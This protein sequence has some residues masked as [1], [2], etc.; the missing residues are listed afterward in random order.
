MTPLLDTLQLLDI[1]DEEYFGTGYRN[2]ISNSR[3]KLMNPDQGGSPQLYHEGLGASSTTESLL[4]GS[5]VHCIVLQPDD[6]VIAPLTTRPTAKL[7]LVADEVYPKFLEKLGDYMENTQ[8]LSEDIIAA[9]NKIDYYK[10]KMTAERIQDVITKCDAYW[11]GRM[12]WESRSQNEKEPIFLDAKSWEVVHECIKSVDKNPKIQQLLHPKGVTQDPI[13]LNEGTLLMD[14]KAIV[15]GHETILKLK[16]KL[17][18]FT[19]D[20]E[21]NTIVLNDLKTTGHFI[22]DFGNGSFVNFHYARQMSFYLWLLRLYAQKAYGMEHPKMYA[23]MMLVSTIPDYRSGI[24]ACNTKEIAEGFKEFKRLLRMV[25]YCEVYGYD[26][27]LGT[28][29]DGSAFNL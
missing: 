3:L 27:G 14:V 17:D 2:Y 29:I 8:V 4:R 7:G 1:S 11:H 12:D 21:T 9:S 20:L 28:D 23:N 10:G 6:F 26:G 5:A 25:A 18:S 15:D 16:A 19:I 13:V 24:Y 22:V